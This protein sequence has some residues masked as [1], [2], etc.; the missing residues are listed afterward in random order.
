[1]D[2]LLGVM[3][4]PV[5]RGKPDICDLVEF[6]Q[7]FHDAFADLFGSDFPAVFVLQLRDNPLDRRLDFFG[8]DGPF[9][10]SAVDAIAQLAPVKLLI[11]TGAFLDAHRLVEDLLIRR[12]ARPAI[13]AFAATTNLRAVATTARV[14]DLVVLFATFGATHFLGRSGNTRF[15]VGQEY[16]ILTRLK[17]I[18]HFLLVLAVILIA[19]SL[20]LAWREPKMMYYPDRTPFQ[21]PAGV[22][23]LNL[24]ASD[25][26]KIHGWNVPGPPAAPLTVLFFHGNAGNLAHRTEKLALLQQL[27]VNTCII[28]YRGYGRSDGTPNEQGTYR[29][30]LAA[31][32]FLTTNRE[33]STIVLYGESLG[34]GVAVELATRVPVA[35]IILEEGYTS[36]GDVAQSMFPCL[37]VRYL[38]RNKYDSINK[39]PRLHVPVLIFHSR[40]DEIFSYR[41]AERLFAAAHDPKRLV[42]LHGNHNDAFYQSL[43]IYR[44]ALKDFFEKLAAARPAR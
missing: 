3:K 1:M 8:T 21:T 23:D 39:L 11:I 42:E 43:D 29:D 13:E 38:V 37:P 41:H 33:P 24:T 27:G 10:A 2:E 6:T 28:D 5:D 16:V 32:N 35:G 12:E 34:T 31:Y 18:M 40:G 4:L 22:T 15:P 26:V 20:L 17:R 9:L 44:A 36:I 30:A 7:M 25:G 14:N 19:F